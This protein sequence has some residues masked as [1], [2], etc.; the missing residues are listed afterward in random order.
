MG[1]DATFVFDAGKWADALSAVL[2]DRAAAVARRAP[3]YRDAEFWRSGHALGLGHIRIASA[4]E[5][6]LRYAYTGRR[7]DVSEEAR[8]LAAQVEVVGDLAGA[9]VSA[10]TGYIVVPEFHLASSIVAWANTGVLPAEPVA[11]AQSIARDHR[12]AQG[13]LAEAIAAVPR[14]GGWERALV[15]EFVPEFVAAVLLEDWA[16]VDEAHNSGFAYLDALKKPSAPGL[17]ARFC[18]LLRGAEATR[19]HDDIAACREALNRYAQSLADSLIADE[20][21]DARLSWLFLCAYA[22]DRTVAGVRSSLPAVNRALLGR[23]H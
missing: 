4:V 5:W 13:G 23:G 9:R 15:R 2:P 17:I 14:S 10:E 6:L 21:W 16:W 7:G 3:D 12:A 1:S 19:T 22:F 20:P 8:V 18:I 11:R